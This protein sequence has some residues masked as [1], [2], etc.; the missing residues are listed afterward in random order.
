VVVNKQTTINTENIM[1]NLKVMRL[2]QPSVEGLVED[3]STFA[4]AF[5]ALG[6]PTPEEGSLLINGAT[7]AS[8]GQVIA[9][10]TTVHFNARPKGA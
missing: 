7:P 4:S 5:E 2:G 3:G 10:D 8:P 9:G 6:L 1:P